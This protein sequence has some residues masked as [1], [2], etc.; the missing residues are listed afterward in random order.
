MKEQNNNN[1]VYKA[2]PLYT[3]SNN[4][5][6]RLLKILEKG[7]KLVTFLTTLY[8][9]N[10]PGYTRSVKYSLIPQDMRIIFI[11]YTLDPLGFENYI[12][13]TYFLI[14]GCGPH[15]Q[16]SS[17]MAADEI[18]LQSLQLQSLN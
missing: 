11:K 17:S 4:T 12:S 6:N 5:L 3:G 10:S 15:Y 16:L 13:L 8:L 18:P 2:A 14:P 7:N 1:V 9:Q